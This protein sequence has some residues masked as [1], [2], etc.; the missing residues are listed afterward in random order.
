MMYSSDNM[1]AMLLMLSLVIV[2]GL[3][4]APNEPTEHDLLA[5]ATVECEQGNQDACQL[6]RNILTKQDKE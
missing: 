4:I 3:A 5:W 6:E 2:V 1:M